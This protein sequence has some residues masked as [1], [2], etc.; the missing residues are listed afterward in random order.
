MPRQGRGTKDYENSTW[1]TL[2]L[3]LF[4]YYTFFDNYLAIIGASSYNLGKLS[5]FSGG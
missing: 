1:R 3:I 2:T 5:I 4:S